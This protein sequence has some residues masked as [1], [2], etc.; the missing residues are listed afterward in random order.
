MIVWQSLDSNNDSKFKRVFL[1]S[2]TEL[3]STLL[4]WNRIIS[5]LRTENIKDGPAIEIFNSCFI[6]ELDQTRKC[7]TSIW[8][9]IWIHI[10]KDWKAEII[11]KC[12]LLNPKVKVSC[13]DSKKLLCL[14]Q[15]SAL[16]LIQ[17]GQHKFEQTPEYQLLFK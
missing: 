13:S 9:E 7:S 10:W 11:C 1:S 5:D 6:T 12:L 16:S 4:H 14:N 15:A 3:L 17:T 8:S 2:S